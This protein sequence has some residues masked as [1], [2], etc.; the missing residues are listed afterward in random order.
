MSSAA[1]A[2]AVASEGAGSERAEPAGQGDAGSTAAASS[3]PQ[4]THAA[5][6]ALPSAED[7]SSVGVKSSIDGVERQL[8]QLALQQGQST[9][10]ASCCHLADI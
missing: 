10:G 8:Q 5:A 3:Q 7:E 4:A 2:G 6:D 1:E 9:A